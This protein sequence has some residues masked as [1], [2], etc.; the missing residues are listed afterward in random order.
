MAARFRGDGLASRWR[1]SSVVSPWRDDILASRWR[2]SSVTSCAGDAWAGGRAFAVI[3]SKLRRSS[4][5]LHTPDGDWGVRCAA[6]YSLRRARA[7]L[8]RRSEFDGTFATRALCSTPC[9]K[10]RPSFEPF[11]AL[12]GL[13]LVTDQRRGFTRARLPALVVLA[14]TVCAGMLRGQRAFER[15]ARARDVGRG[16]RRG[17]RHDERGSLTTFGRHDRTMPQYFARLKRSTFF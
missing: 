13:V 11:V 5:P 9:R 8:F 15:D 1:G 14:V 6:P 4:R 7:A 12:A 16:A 2:G 17:E 10:V 3:G